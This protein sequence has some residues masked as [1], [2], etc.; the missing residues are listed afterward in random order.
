MIKATSVQRAPIKA[1]AARSVRAHS[2]R[3]NAPFV[4]VPRI[5]TLYARLCG[6]LYSMERS[7]GGIGA[8]VP[9]TSPHRHSLQPVVP[10][11]ARTLSLPRPL[12]HTYAHSKICTCRHVAAL[13]VN[14]S[15]HPGVVHAGAV[16]RVSVRVLLL[17]PSDASGRPPEGSSEGGSCGGQVGAVV[18]VP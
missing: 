8:S 14:A 5:G 13:V 18:L 12:S 4:A 7:V 10:V 11:S 15:E 3:A 9:G 1:T 2:A 16:C 6:S 17:H